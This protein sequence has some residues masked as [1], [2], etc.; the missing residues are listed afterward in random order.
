[1]GARR[2]SCPTARRAGAPNDCPERSEPEPSEPAS[3]GL[4]SPGPVS[5]EPG[6][7]EPGSPEP[8][9]AAEP[10]QGLDAPHP[11]LACAVDLLWPH[12]PPAPPGPVEPHPREP[13]ARRAER[14]GVQLVADVRRL[15]RLEAEPA[16]TLGEHPR[17]GLAEAER[18][19]PDQHGKVR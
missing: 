4:A 18:V 6:S 2:S 1:R 13:R 17:V 9:R 16:R 19:D 15:P 7:L 5:L 10:A 8:E 14:V 12:R 3:P 11:L